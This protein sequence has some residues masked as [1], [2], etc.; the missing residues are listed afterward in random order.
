MDT[1]KFDDSNILIDTDDLPDGITLKDV[2]I[3]IL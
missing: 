3:L 1:E 2:V